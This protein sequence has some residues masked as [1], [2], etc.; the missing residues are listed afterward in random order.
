VG[1]TYILGIES[2]CDETAAAVVR[3]GEELISNVVYSQIATHHPYGG[4]VPELA[5]REHLRT[6]VPVVRKALKDAG[7]TYETIDAIAVTQGPG[8]AGSLLVGLSYAKGLA[9]ALDKPLIAVNHLEGHIHAVLLEERQ[10]GTSELLFPVLALVVSGGHTHLYLAERRDRGWAYRNIGHT[11]DD[12]AGEAFDKVAKLL[13]LG[14]PGGP[15]IDLLA[16]HGNPNAV[17][18]PFAQIK[19]RDRN[20]QNRH[21]AGE[22]RTDFSY[23]GIKTAVLRYVEV[24]NMAES[25][26]R[27]REVIKT[28][29]KPTP[30]DY[31]GACDCQTLDLIA[32]FQ[33]AV[34]DDLVSK[35]LS[36]AME[37]GVATLLVTGGVAANSELRK[38]FETRANEEGIPVL[39]PS[40]KLATDNAAM[41]AAAA[42][43]RFLA[44]EFA[45]PELSSDP[46]L[47][48]G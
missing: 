16:P 2:S 43:P 22:R 42:Y 1:D 9:F 25:I 14:Y 23:S 28:I 8:L 41:I 15:V 44:G 13:E 5:S 17:K 21:P 31:L 12:A 37:Y 24:H 46:A 38:T 34:V 27:R 10:N 29:A 35:T 40:R 48:L 30:R 11:R 36:A 33:R 6:I 7:Q 4:I 26:Q 3:S 18:F 32:S 20:P 19:H 39:F 45:D 47:R